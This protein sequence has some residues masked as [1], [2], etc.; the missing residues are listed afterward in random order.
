M[1]GEDGRPR[2]QPKDNRWKWA[3]YIAVSLLFVGATIGFV[4][5]FDH[6]KNDSASPNS[7]AVEPLE[8]PHICDACYAIPGFDEYQTCKSCWF[9]AEEDKDLACNVG[10]GD[11]KITNV[12][13]ASATDLARI[14][15]ECSMQEDMFDYSSGEPFVCSFNLAELRLDENNGA[16]ID[17]AGAETDY[18]EEYVDNSGVDTEGGEPVPIPALSQ[19]EPWGMEDKPFPWGP[20][21]DKPEFGGQIEFGFM[22]KQEEPGFPGFP[23]GPFPVGSEGFPPAG[24]GPNDGPR[25][26]RRPGRPDHRPHGPHH[27]P[28]RHHEGIKIDYVCSKHEDEPV[29]EEVPTFKLRSTRRVEKFMDEPLLS[30][31]LVKCGGPLK[32]LADTVQVGKACASDNWSLTCDANG[33]DARIIVLKFKEE[34]APHSHK[35]KKIGKARAKLITNK[36]VGSAGSCDFT[37]DDFMTES[38][39]A[40][41]FAGKNYKVKYLCSYGEALPVE[42]PVDPEPHMCC[43]AMTPECM[44]CTEGITVAEYCAIPENAEI[45]GNQILRSSR[46]EAPSDLLLE[47]ALVKCG[48]TKAMSNTVD[49]GKVCADTDFDL[50][51][52][53]TRTGARVIVL[54]FKDSSMEK[55]VVKA[56]KKAMKKT[57]KSRAAA[58]TDICDAQRDSASCSFTL[59]DVVEETTDLTSL[60]DHVF[61]VKYLCSYDA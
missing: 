18:T 8:A 54:K 17:D 10:Y 46:F 28:H 38:E 15:E 16:E 6:K 35:N 23:F 59:E 39:N 29:V 3:G 26:P 34:G 1:L 49:I 14:A 43:K 61:N 32:T 60:V 36:C 11:L 20:G 33:V 22:D 31:A 51:C 27:G 42:A 40:A 48:S 9:K 37:V 41:D 4:M 5:H 47:S 45:C 55:P 56:D 53:D 30:S 57:M 50:A 12:K 25:E 7:F 13:H 21:M 19:A 44:A 52:D 58:A 24:F 2:T